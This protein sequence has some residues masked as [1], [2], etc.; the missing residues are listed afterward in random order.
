LG[1]AAVAAQ[2]VA[3][4][5]LLHLRP[6]AVRPHAQDVVLECVCVPLWLCAVCA[7]RLLSPG[8]GHTRA[9]R[10]GVVAVTALLQATALS[11]SP[12]TSDDDYRYMWDAKVQL[13]GVD[14]YRYPPEAT[15]LTGLRDDFLFPDADAAHCAHAIPH[16][17]TVINRPQVHTVYPPVAQ[18]AFDAV[19]LVSWGGRGGHLPLQLAA[20]LGVL[21][22][23]ALLL[24]R[25]VPP[26]RTALFAWSPLAVLDYGNNAHIDWLAIVLCVFALGARRARVAG[27]ACGAAI[28][29]KL[30][31]VLV[32]PSLMRRSWTAGI[33]AAALVV[34][35]YLP[36]V[37]AVGRA[38]IGYLPGYLHEEDYLSGNRLQVLGLAL[39]HPADSVAGVAI[40]AAACVWAWRVADDAVR[41]AT[42]V[43]G[44]AV[45]VFTPAYGWYAGLLLALVALS[46][47]LVWL[48]A[49]VAGDVAYVTRAGW[50]VWPIACGLAVMLAAARGR[51]KPTKLRA[52]ARHASSA[53][54]PAAAP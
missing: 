44:V 7:L 22:T 38:V 42:L 40:V 24:R 25:G 27:A 16:G 46:G 1:A 4:A 23:T 32:L 51:V 53:T 8:G 17:C 37:L 20:A 45:C 36:H 41:S 54:S 14:P 30:Y 47:S 13:A 18:G 21:L 29:V 43:V 19:R 6:A 28:A 3:Y 52:P 49:A 5:V 48:P 11:A 10:W 39:P 26:W 12:T 2:V 9:G 33:A 35:V 50:L 31:P 34:L 15:Q